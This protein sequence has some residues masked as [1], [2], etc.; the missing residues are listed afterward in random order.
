[1]L[2]KQLPSN[3][4]GNECLPTSL[5]WGVLAWGGCLEP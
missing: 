3:L 4:I 1:M 2:Y 5:V